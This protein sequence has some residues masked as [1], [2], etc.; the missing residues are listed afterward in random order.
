MLSRKKAINKQWHFVHAFFCCLCTC[1]LG[2]H[3]SIF[4]WSESQLHIFV[5]NLFFRYIAE[6]ALEFGFYECFCGKYY[7]SFSCIFLMEIY[8]YWKMV[9]F[10]MCDVELF[11]H[12]YDLLAVAVIQKFRSARWRLKTNVNQI[13]TYQSFKR[14]HFDDFKR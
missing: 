1:M 9:N 6:H 13:H 14:T 8:I 12:T 2:L 4:G 10:A 3:I 11:L 7:L 5:L